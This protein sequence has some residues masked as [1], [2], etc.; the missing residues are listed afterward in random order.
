VDAPRYRRLGATLAD[1]HAATAAIA[2]PPQ[3][4]GFHEAVF[5]ALPA[6]GGAPRREALLA[7]ADHADAD[8]G[9]LLRREL[10]A[11]EAR[12][13]P[14]VFAGAPRRIVQADF[15]PW[16]LRFRG[17]RL[18]A[19]LDFELAHVDVEAMDLASARRGYHDAVVTGYLARWPLPAAHVAALDA[20]WIG[21]LFSVVWTMLEAV[22]R[23][24]VLA[25][26]AFAWHAD[27]FAKTR[28][29]AGG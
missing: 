16:N 5:G 21:S 10:A 26:D 18:S 7:L 8:L 27:Q 28:P 14:G 9:R 17:G 24:G 2:C 11:L 22:E 15:V 6:A 29:F 4:P 13:L 19:L 25:P 1:V 20:L 23:T 3:R 12:D